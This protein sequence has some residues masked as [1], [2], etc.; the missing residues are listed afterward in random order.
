MTLCPAFF[1]AFGR[2]AALANVSCVIG[3]DRWLSLLTVASFG[4][5]VNVCCWMIGTLSGIFVTISNDT[6]WNPI[7]TVT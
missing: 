5:V 1:V 6:K 4:V 3:A 2:F 7:I